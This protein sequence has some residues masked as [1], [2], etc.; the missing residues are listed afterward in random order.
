M[1]SSP[2]TSILKDVSRVEWGEGPL[3]RAADASVRRRLKSFIKDE[4]SEPVVLF[5]DEHKKHST[6]GDWYGEHVGKWLVAASSACVRLRDAELADSIVRVV[7][8]IARQQEQNGYL[9]TYAGSAPCRFTSSDAESVRTWDVW[10]HAWLVLGLLK[11]HSIPGAEVGAESAVRIGDLLLDT[12]PAVHESVLDLGNHAGLSSAIVIEPLAELSLYTGDKRYAQLALHTLDQISARGLKLVEA[13]EEEIDVS[14]IGTGKAYQIIWNL[15]GLVALYRATGEDRLLKAAKNLW[16]NIR[17][18]HLTPLGGPWGGIAAHKEVFDPKGFFSPF[19]MVETCS[20]AT[21]MTLSRRLFEVT[22]D[23]QFVEEFERTLLNTILGAA[24]P[25]GVDWCYFTFPN[26]RRNNT[27]HWACC[28]SSGAMALEEAANLACIELAGVPHVN[29]HES[30]K[31]SLSGSRELEIVRASNSVR[32]HGR[33]IERVAVRMPRWVEGEGGYRCVDLV[34][35][36]AEVDLTAQSR[37]HPF[38][39][40]VD[41]HGQEIVRTDYAY[42]SRGPYIYATGLIDGYK[43]EETLRLARLTPEAPFREAEGDAIELRLPKRDPILFE[44]Y[45]RAGGQHDG[46]WRSTWMQVAWQ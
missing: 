23:L 24:D 42:L 6:S 45:Y 13:A 36:S 41:H 37:V 46:A 21:W 10:V 32:L 7:Q 17:D 11:A 38:T 2:G 20:A 8:H 9:G 16:T 19:G 34:D 35:G 43:K 27:Y 14:T 1:I 25:N 5:D 12:F 28:K 15:V 3:G 4:E 33:G 22:G 39:Y 44:P 40:T 31:I 18:H 30:A 26:G 29:L